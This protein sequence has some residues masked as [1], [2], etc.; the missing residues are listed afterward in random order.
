[1]KKLIQVSLIVVV[2]FMLL[3]AAI[4]GAFVSTDKMASFENTHYVAATVSGQNIQG[5]SC[6]NGR[7]INCVLPQVGWN[8]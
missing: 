5:F 7:V 6:L 2:V 1:M 3:Q 8:S 4:G